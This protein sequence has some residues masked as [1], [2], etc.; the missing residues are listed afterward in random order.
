MKVYKYILIVTF[1]FSGNFACQNLFKNG[2]ERRIEVIKRAIDAIKKQDTSDLYRVIDTSYIFH[3][4]G[5]EGF[6]SILEII[7][8]HLKDCPPQFDNIKIE[9]NVMLQSTNFIL[10][11]C[12][13]SESLVF[14]FADYDRKYKIQNLTAEF[15]NL[16][17][18][19]KSMGPPIIRPDTIK[20]P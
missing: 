19:I 15:G 8:L 6:M 18:L 3:L 10:P 11:M 20:I 4:P 2:D 5:K 13:N 9:K 7:Q 17:E 12:I 16:E 14:R 1:V